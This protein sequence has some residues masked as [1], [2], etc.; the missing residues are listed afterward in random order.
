[1]N[2]SQTPEGNSL[3]V[4]ASHHVS[5][6]P[7]VDHPSD[8]ATSLATMVP[9]EPAGLPASD[10]GS[11]RELLRVAIPLIISAGSQSLMNVVDRMFLTWW[12]PN[13]LAASLPA[14]LL[15]WT[16]L[17]LPFG[18]VIYSN[19]FI[20]Q[21]EG[22]GR[23]NR[24]AASL[25]QGVWMALIFGAVITSLV[26]LFTSGID[27]LG[28]DPDVTLLEKSYFSILCYGGIFMLLNQALTAYFSGRGET[29][30]VMTVN[31][32]ASFTNGIFDYLL[33]FGEGPFPMLG[34]QGAAIATV[35]ANALACVIYGVLIARRAPAAGYPIRQECRFDLV[36]IRRMIRFGAHKGC[37]TSST[38][39]P[40]RYT[41]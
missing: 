34:I 7:T 24:V 28:H 32:I 4:D 16:V 21:Y 35:G 12:D 19:T 6:T 30:T 8:A 31:I 5:A 25:W 20:A 15:N 18:I 23:K 3:R 9:D 2:D 10:A 41:W 39:R 36:L 29:W 13:A 37:S 27:R 33:I 38:S 1:M 26:P 22:V 14:I 40:S 17:A 11:M